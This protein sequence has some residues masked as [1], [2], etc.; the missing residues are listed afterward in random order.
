MLPQE[1]L[2]VH[3][4]RRRSWRRPRACARYLMLAFR[5]MATPAAVSYPLFRRCSRP[6][7][8]PRPLKWQ[9]P[10]RDASPLVESD[11][12][13]PQAIRRP[14]YC[15]YIRQLL[16]NRE[17]L[18]LAIC[19]DDVRSML[20]QEIFGPERFRRARRKAAGLRRRGGP[21]WPVGK[22]FA[23]GSRLNNKKDCQIFQP[24]HGER[25]RRASLHVQSKPVTRQS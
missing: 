6:C 12:E 22:A 8:L 2:R 25:R 19:R 11:A 14:I 10:G 4:H 9:Q 16:S 23:L 20:S 24:I 21:H 15:K 17:L 3:R 7:R 5:P 18:S 13:Q 1:C